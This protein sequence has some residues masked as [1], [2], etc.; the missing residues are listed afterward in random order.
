MF[1]T[2]ACHV[3][4]RLFCKVLAMVRIDKPCHVIS[5]NSMNTVDTEAVIIGA[6]LGGL[7]SAILLGQMGIK[8]AV[9]ERSPLPGGLLRS[10]AR[11]GVDCAV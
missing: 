2:T 11:Q 7:T 9:I 10:Y 1:V 8:V 6:G 5:T 4:F 3:R